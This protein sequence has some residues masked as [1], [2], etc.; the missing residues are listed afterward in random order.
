[1]R[2]FRIAATLALAVIAS[3]C[4]QYAGV[5]QEHA[6]PEVRIQNA[7]RSA[8]VPTVAPTS[9][10]PS[11]EPDDGVNG[12]ENADV[13]GDATTITNLGKGSKG[14]T[15]S[16][17]SKKGST[18]GSKK[19]STDGSKSGSS[20]GSKSGSK[21][22][23]GSSDGSK[24]GSSDGSKSGSKTGSKDGKGDSTSNSTSG[25]HSHSGKTKDGND[26]GTSGDARDTTKGDD[27]AN[28]PGDGSTSTTGNVVPDSVQEVLQ[29]GAKYNLRVLPKGFPFQ[30]CPVWGRYAYSDDYGAPRYAGG[31]HP[32]AGNDIFAA[33]GTPVLAPF[34]GY[35]EK[36]ENTLGGQAVRVHGA[37]GYV[38]MAHLIAYSHELQYP[39]PVVAGTVVGFVGNTGDAQATSPHDHFEWHPNAVQSYDRQIDG[40]NGAVDPF[41][42]LRVVC[43]PS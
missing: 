30:I 33:M 8:A 40:T 13:T 23:K 29:E 26:T 7:D 15:D 20:D 2:S 32:H 41:P 14:S 24:S 27:G 25:S 5:H 37:L 34:D 36:A 16:G 42:Y 31:Y 6:A 12:P 38:Y 39:A 43:P 19:G 4:G 22:S 11:I 35:V 21:G 18:D 1:M 3:A 10:P 17:G 9:A 28:G